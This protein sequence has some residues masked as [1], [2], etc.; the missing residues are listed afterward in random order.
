MGIRRNAIVTGLALLATVSG[1][2]ACETQT[3]LGSNWPTASSNNAPTTGAG[4][5]AGANAGVSVGANPGTGGAPGASPPSPAVVQDLMSRWNLAV[6]SSQETIDFRWRELDE[7]PHPTFKGGTAQA[8][9][10][11][12]S[13]LLAFLQS[14]FDFLAQNHLFTMGLR[15]N[16]TSGQGDVVTSFEQLA[17]SFSSSTAFGDITPDVHAGLLQ[18]AQR[19][20]QL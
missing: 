11:F 6:D 16:T 15:D 5:T 18:V 1:T 17:D 10:Q 13:I 9:G 12:A 8:Y 7:F 4:G 14:N 20:H 19:I 2:L 3:P